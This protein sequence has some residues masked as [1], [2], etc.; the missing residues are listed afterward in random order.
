[1]AWEFEGNVHDSSDQVD[2]FMIVRFIKIS[3]LIYRNFI[4]FFVRTVS[5]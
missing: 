1:M 4:S 3:L 2:S 5:T